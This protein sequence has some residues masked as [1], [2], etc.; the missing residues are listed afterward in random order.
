MKCSDIVGNMVRLDP[1]LFIGKNV[2]AYIKREPLDLKIAILVHSIFIGLAAFFLTPYLL[3]ITLLRNLAFAGVMSLQ[4]L[5]IQVMARGISIRRQP[6][7]FEAERV[8]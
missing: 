7:L 3:P 4:F 8:R 5:F 6:L 1:G 2:A